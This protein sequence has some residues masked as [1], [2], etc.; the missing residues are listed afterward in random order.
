MSALAKS[1]KY[2]LDDI[3]LKDVKA[4]EVKL[5]ALIQYEIRSVADLEAWLAQERTLNDEIQEAMMGH[6][7][8]FYRCKCRQA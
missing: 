7:I 3:N 1:T 6:K 5:K 2:Y 8:D 4:L